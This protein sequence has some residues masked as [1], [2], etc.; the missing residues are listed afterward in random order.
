MNYYNSYN[1]YAPPSSY[2]AYSQN[3][4]QQ[5][6]SSIVEKGMPLMTNDLTETTFMAWLEFSKELLQ[7]ATKDTVAT[8]YINYLQLIITLHSSRLTPY[9]KLY[10]CLQFLLEVMKVT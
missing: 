1:P 4:M 2:G 5:T 10:Y 8:T 9:Q 7:I 3:F 6:L